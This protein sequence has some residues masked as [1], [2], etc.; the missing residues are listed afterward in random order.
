MTTSISSAP[1]S[2]GAPDFGDTFGERRKTG[3]EAR[4]DRGHMNPTSFDSAARRFDERVVHAHGRYLDLR[5]FNAKL[6][7]DS[8]LEGLARFGAK[9]KHALVSIVTGKRGEVHARNGAQQ[10]RGLPFFLHRASSHQGLRA[11]LHGAGVHADG[12]HPIQVERYAAV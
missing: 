7:H 10:P 11:A 6:L 9:P 4:R 5:A 1:A 12:I 8:L 3:R 2:N